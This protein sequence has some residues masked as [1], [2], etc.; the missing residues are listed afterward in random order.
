MHFSKML[1]IVIFPAED[2]CHSGA[3]AYIT[4][5]GLKIVVFFRNMSGQAIWSR[6]LFGTASTT[7]S[8]VSSTC[9]VALEFSCSFET[10]LA[11]TARISLWPA[12]PPAGRFR[13]I[14]SQ[15]LVGGGPISIRKPRCSVVVRGHWETPRSAVFDIY[16]R[17]ILIGQTMVVRTRVLYFASQQLPFS[18]I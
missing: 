4:G 15:I 13:A 12:N 18:C 11:R 17:T 14:K 6:V 16:Q 3:R 9:S 7:I 5:T 2:L 1:V 10:F 8:C